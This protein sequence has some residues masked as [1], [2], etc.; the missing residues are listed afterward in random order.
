MPPLPEQKEKASNVLIASTFVS[1]ILMGCVNFL[2][3][4]VMY[5]AYGEKYSFFV[6]Q[7]VNFLFVVYGGLIVYPMQLFTDKITPEMTAVP[8]KKF[9]IMGL[10][11]CF[12]TFFTAMGAVY[13]PGQFQ[14]LLNQ[15]LIPLT[16]V[17]SYIF[18]R[19]RYSRLQYIGAAL[20]L[21]GAASVVIP[22]IVT[23]SFSRDKL[24]WYSCIVYVMSNIPMACSAVYKEY[25]FKSYSIN[26]IYVTQWVSIFQLFF[27]FLLAPLQLIP[28]IGP[29]GC[30]SFADILTFFSDG[31]KCCFEIDGMCSGKYTLAL[32]MGYVFINFCFNTTG[33]YMTKHGSA[34][35]NS[36]VFAVLLPVTTLVFSFKFLGEY[37]EEL[38]YFTAIGL[39]FVLAGVYL[40]QFYS[41]KVDS[42]GGL[43][44][45]KLV[46]PKETEANDDIPSTFQERIVGM[47]KAHRKSLI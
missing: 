22:S 6:S 19:T 5:T 33:L 17:A 24:R 41:A 29:E 3:Y 38:S 28:G 20:I 31:W 47:G 18:L 21:T 44:E 34:V 23:A 11:D 2:T 35:L 46:L 27:G 30:N 9:M 16:M 36:T 45:M 42:N 40:Y 32:I 26:V 15:C 8:K 1:L 14:T 7:G 37:R 10:L 39:A 4:K 12:G 43:E 13:T 25:A